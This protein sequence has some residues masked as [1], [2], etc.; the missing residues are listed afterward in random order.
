MTVESYRDCYQ[1]LEDQVSLLMSVHIHMT[2]YV[3]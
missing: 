1:Y 3:I 2:L